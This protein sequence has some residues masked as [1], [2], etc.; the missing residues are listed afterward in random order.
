MGLP[1]R[2]RAISGAASDPRRRP[3]F[4]RFCHEYNAGQAG[5]WDNDIVGHCTCVRHGDVHPGAN[6]SR[7]V[8]TNRAVLRD[9]PDPYIPVPDGLTSSVIA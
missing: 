4:G 3:Y 6:V 9:S 2:E 5:N 8:D 1:L 7:A